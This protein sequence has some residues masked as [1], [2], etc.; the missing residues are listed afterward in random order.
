[1][2][3]V[4]GDK[5]VRSDFTPMCQMF[6]GLSRDSVSITFSLTYL[7]PSYPKQETKTATLFLWPHAVTQQTPRTW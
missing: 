4:T 1:M 3:R 2:I 6:L 7:N 5:E